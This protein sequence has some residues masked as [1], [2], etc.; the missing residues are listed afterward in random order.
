MLATRKS[1]L[2]AISQRGLSTNR[3][4]TGPLYDAMMI[5]AMH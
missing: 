3:D 1:R 2:I 5:I 4:L